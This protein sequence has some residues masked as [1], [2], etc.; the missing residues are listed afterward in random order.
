MLW[1]GSCI[2]HALAGSLKFLGVSITVKIQYDGNL[3][4]GFAVNQMWIS[5][6]P[7]PL[8]SYMSLSKLLK[9]SKPQFTV[10]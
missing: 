7:P 10:K 6:L 1:I 5:V 9:I 3:V 8:T 4:D 2:S